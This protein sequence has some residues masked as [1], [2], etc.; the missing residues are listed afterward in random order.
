MSAESHAN[1]VSQLHHQL[2]AGFAVVE[3]DR[4]Q[5]RATTG[6]TPTLVVSVKHADGRVPILE[7]V[8]ANRI[9]GGALRATL[10]ENPT[11]EVTRLARSVCLVV[12]GTVP[13]GSLSLA[14]WLEAGAS[15]IHVTETLSFGRTASPIAQLSAEWRLA[16]WAPPGEVFSSHLTP[17]EDDIIGAHCLRSPVLTAQD[18]RIAA[19]MVQ[20]IDSLRKQHLV[21]AFM[22]LNR[23]DDVPSFVTGLVKQVVR[24]HVFFR[25]TYE[26][27]V[28]REL[29]HSYQLFAGA[30]REPGAALL[31]AR[32]HLWDHAGRPSLSAARP[33]RAQAHELAIETYPR[34][35]AEKWRETRMEGR[36]AGAITTDRVFPGDVWMCPWFHNLSTGYGLFAWGEK[37]GRS[38][39]IEQAIAVREL[40]LAAPMERG[41]FPTLFVFGQD[42]ASDRWE[43]SHP[44]G[45]ALDVLHVGDMSYTMYWLLLYER[46]LRGD[47]RTI[48]RSRAYLAALRGLARPDGGLPAYVSRGT[49]QPVTRIDMDAWKRAL[50]EHPGG[51]E[52]ILQ[53]IDRWGTER[54]IESAE[55]G[56]S[57]MFAAEL[58][59]VPDLDATTRQE[60]NELASRLARWIIERVVEPAWY[61]D[62][63]VY[64]SCAPN[65]LGLYD[66]RSGQH[67]QNLLAIYMAA[68]GL[69]TLYET[70]KDSGHLAAARRA[71]D[72][73]SLYQQVYDPPFLGFDA[74]GGYPA[75]NTDGEWSDARQALFV[76]T[77]LDFYR[78]TGDTEHLDRARAACRASFATLFHPA[79]SD[80]YPVGW[81]RTP[82]GFAAENHAHG[83]VDRTCGVSSFHWG[84]GSALMAAAYL[85]RRGIAAW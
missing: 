59:K 5:L 16:S 8:G 60:A 63:E 34:A 24:S 54:F 42:P 30:G 67:P 45:G 48:E 28:T 27:V 40:H 39:W 7:R 14:L 50:R 29:S 36:R 82:V 26:P 15:W 44:Q 9:E 71:M 61:I 78:L 41:L 80:Q 25:A 37:L 17:E 13:G 72:R 4:L 53:T 20:S 22:S 32:R 38:D 64:W 11:L 1:A 33:L 46:D 58:L 49:H 21:P 55:D 35:M 43:G 75:Q 79:V 74:F 66:H 65:A 76:P 12:R 84:T 57:L 23:S 3:N 85:D 73:L 70:S 47:P 62:M 69:A 52:Y 19:A 68:Q 10:P 77:H 6:T 31:E 81:S 83:G 18:D 51:D 56:A 2:E